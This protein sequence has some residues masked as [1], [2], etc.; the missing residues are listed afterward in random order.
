MYRTININITIYIKYISI[1]HAVF[2]GITPL[3]PFGKRLTKTTTI[4][5]GKSMA[6][7]H[8]PSDRPLGSSRLH[9]P[10]KRATTDGT[11]EMV[12]HI[13]FQNIYENIKMAKQ[14]WQ[15]I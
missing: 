3:I 7:G 2:F 15:N 9:R 6:W 11:H 13:V 14:K 10:K 1:R 8:R 5:M 4:S 12:K